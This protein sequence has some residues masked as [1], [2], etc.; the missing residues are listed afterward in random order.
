MCTLNT[1]TMCLLYRP[2]AASTA[3]SKTLTACSW[4]Y[5]ARNGY[6][7]YLVQHT[8]PLFPHSTAMS[9]AVTHSKPP[10]PTACT[11]PSRSVEGVPY[12]SRSTTSNIFSCCIITMRT[13]WP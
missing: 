12:G 7:P 2:A 13:S 3:L 1:G 4:Q 6:D 8:S 5:F 10:S 9:V 11:A